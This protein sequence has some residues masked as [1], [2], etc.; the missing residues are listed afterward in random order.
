LGARGRPTR[1][2][3]AQGERVCRHARQGLQPP[4]AWP[5]NSRAGWRPNRRGLFS[6]PLGLETR[7][8]RSTNPAEKKNEKKIIT[9]IIIIIIIIIIFT[10]KFYC[11]NWPGMFD[12]IINM[13]NIIIYILNIIVIIVIKSINIKNRRKLEKK[14]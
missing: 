5:T 13:R 3:A 8:V 10:K 4:S 12:I 2:A 11:R 7:T 6:Q 9:I 1:L 14:I